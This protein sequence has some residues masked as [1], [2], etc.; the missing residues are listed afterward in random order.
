[1]G[2]LGRDC[3]SA[4]AAFVLNVVNRA[5]SAHGLAALK[6]LRPKRTGI[7]AYASSSFARLLALPNSH[8][9]SESAEPRDCSVDRGVAQA[10]WG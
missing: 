2:D 3:T 6:G 10:V 8:G 1:M 7:P 9:V 5:R 4:E